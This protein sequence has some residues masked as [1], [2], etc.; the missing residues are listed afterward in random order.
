M[1][2]ICI[3][4]FLLSTIVAIAQDREVAIDEFETIKTFDLIKVNL[5]KADENKILFQG[6]DGDD[7]EFVE[8]DGLLK[9][10][11]KHD[12][13][14]DG[15][16]TFITVYYTDIKTIDANEGSIIYANELMEQDDLELRVQEGA[17]IKAGVRIDNL[18][19]RA[20]TGGIIQLSGK[21]NN[22]QVVVNTGGIIENEDLITAY[23]SVK[24]QAGGEVE[25]HATKSVDV[26]IKAGG[27]VIVYGDPKKVNKK[28]LFG[29][30][31]VIR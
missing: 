23:T 28:T 26:N 4:V 14:F 1:K 27:D 12:K 31:V 8:R 15:Q 3:A 17:T 25:V 6:R 22:Q 24:V 21:V 13:I 20:V 5:V 29:G 2:F 16:N 7:V 18:D 10:R 19:V 11:M 9:V 30:S